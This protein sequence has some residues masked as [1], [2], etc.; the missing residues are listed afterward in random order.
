MRKIRELIAKWFE[1][2]FPE[3]SEWSPFIFSAILVGYLA[4]IANPAFADQSPM[5][6]LITTTG[7]I[8]TTSVKVLNE[9]PR[10]LGMLIY[11]NSSNS[12]YIAFDTTVNSANHMTAIIPTF[13]SWSAPTPC[14]MGAVSAIRNAGAGALMITEWY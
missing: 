2:E 14:Y 6:A 1:I 12:V 13:A 8:A 9:N 7:S 10:R 3:L 11:N 5:N 4:I